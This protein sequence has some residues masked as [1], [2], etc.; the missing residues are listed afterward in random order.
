MAW[1][2]AHIGSWAAACAIRLVTGSMLYRVSTTLRARSS[3][4]DS[5]PN[6][7]FV[8]GRRGAEE[9]HRVL[10]VA[11][12]NEEHDEVAHSSERRWH[13]TRRE[14]DGSRVVRQRCGPLAQP[15]TDDVFPPCCRPAQPFGLLPP[16]G[17]H[18]RR[19]TPPHEA[20]PHDRNDPEAPTVVGSTG[21]ST[22][23]HVG[24]SRPTSGACC[25]ARCPSTRAR[26]SGIMSNQEQ[27]V[28]RRT[29]ARGCR[30]SSLDAHFPATAVAV[31]LRRGRREVTAADSGTF[32]RHHRA[33]STEVADRG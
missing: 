11:H 29:D 14:P 3:C 27:A 18:P 17:V 24:G 33:T 7:A 4:S 32:G 22:G 20:T 1:F 8:L 28:T 12:A 6:S 30:R 21:S 2:T 26:S 16:C 23:L 31:I 19:R 9:H 13:G 25:G 15:D 10:V 5:A